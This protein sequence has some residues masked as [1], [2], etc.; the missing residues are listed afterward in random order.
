MSIKEICQICIVIGL[1]IQFFR[2][3]YVDFNGRKAKEPEGFKG[4]IATVLALVLASLIYLGAGAFST[5]IE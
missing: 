2:N 3:L 1:G 5:F 4:S